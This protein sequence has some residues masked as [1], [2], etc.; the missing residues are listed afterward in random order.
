MEP[1]KYKLTRIE[2][3]GAN[4]SADTADRIY[5]GV[6]FEPSPTKKYIF[7]VE[8]GDASPKQIMEMLYHA[9]K[10]LKDFMPDGSLMVPCRNG[11]PAVGIYELKK[12]E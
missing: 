8:V 9:R 1:T 10:A 4:V 5:Q 6:E 7:S 2:P 11:H 3:L 12:V